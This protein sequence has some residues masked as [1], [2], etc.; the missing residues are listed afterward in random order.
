MDE[1]DQ[2]LSHQAEIVNLIAR[3]YDHVSVLTGRIGKVT[4]P[5]NVTLKSY[6]WVRGKKISNIFRYNVL[7]LF[8][9]FLTIFRPDNFKTQ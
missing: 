4:I 1:A 7:S 5:S 9:A 3:E 6:N 8:S 2:L